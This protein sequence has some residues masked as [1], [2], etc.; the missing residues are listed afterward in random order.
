MVVVDTSALIPLALIGRLELVT[1]TFE[2]VHAPKGVRD[3]VVVEGKP[4]SAA[5]EAFLDTATEHETPEPAADIAD[6]EGIAVTDAAVVLLADR[7]DHRLLANDRGLIEVAKA[8]GVETWWL[9][10]LVLHCTKEDELR[11][12]EAKNVLYDLVDTGMNL[13]PKIYAQVQRKLEELGQ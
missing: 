6:L 5:L 7:L 8:H 3:E 1:K 10:T 12:E 9:T 4:G 13:D 2:R 11:T